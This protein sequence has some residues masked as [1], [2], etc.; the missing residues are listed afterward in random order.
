MCTAQKPERLFRTG[1]FWK[2]LSAGI[3]VK[4]YVCSR[5]TA[6]LYTGYR[7]VQFQNGC[8]NFVFVFV[9]EIRL[10]LFFTLAFRTSFGKLCFPKTPPFL[11]QSFRARKVSETTQLITFICAKVDLLCSLCLVHRRNMH[12]FWLNVFS[13]CF[14]IQ[15]RTRQKNPDLNLFKL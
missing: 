5:K 4:A 1:S 15:C 13:T 6:Q 12:D 8:C 3:L 9:F 7:R 10:Q 14:P 2:R 11:G